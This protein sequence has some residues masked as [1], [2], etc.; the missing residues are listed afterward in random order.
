MPS[1]LKHHKL[2]LL[3]WLMSVPLKLFVAQNMPWDI[4]IVPV[5][6]R[7]AQYTLTPVGTLASVAAY[8]L[9]MLEWLHLPA[10]WLTGDVWWTIVLTLLT[11]N[12]LG[13]LAI[14]GL[15]RSMFSQRVGLVAGILFT[16]SEVGVSSSYTAWAQLLLPAFFA[17][18]LYTLWLWVK[19]EKGYWLALSGIIATVAFMTHFSAVLLYP[20]M[21][22]F[23]I[24][25][26]AKWQWNWLIIGAIII[27]LLFTPYILFQIE[28]DFIDARAF[29]TQEPLVSNATLA[30]YESYK[31]EYRSLETPTDTDNT[32]SV[33]PSL[34]VEPSPPIVRPRWQRAIDYALEAPIWYWRAMTTAFITQTRAIN[35]AI[36]QLAP[37]TRTFLTLQHVLLV[38][39]ISTALFHYLRNFK[40]QK[41]LTATPSGRLLLVTGFLTVYIAI[42]LL[43]RTID[44]SSYWMG[45]M[46][47]QYLILAYAISLVPEQNRIINA[48][49]VILLIAYV[50]LQT[51]ERSLRIIQHDDSQFSAFNVSIYR[52]VEAT[53][54]YIA[55]DWDSDAVTI[56]YDILPIMPNLWWVPAWHTIDPFYTMGMNFDFLLS[57]HH[58]IDNTNTDPVGTI[59]PEL[60]DYIVIY[61]P[62]QD[63]YD[64]TQYS[65]QQFG[66]ILVLKPLSP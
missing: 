3:I 15:G 36:P 46:S 23:A 62:R 48:I 55:E 7:N 12:L 57:Y 58:G 30:Q 45:F 27:G 37:I 49:A 39:S 59:Q 14:Y 10:Q 34:P 11:I 56:S 24:V 22:A 31:I 61:T 53:V 64:L 8:N 21:L 1:F 29:I 28:R 43:T 66:T 16:F 18:T 65:V 20:T 41:S 54:D 38:V 32:Q 19:H 5:V 17:M 2:I 9:P 6:A 13:T 60:A 63:Q 26:R 51:T 35:L 4:D 42:M 44:N 50:G 33:A 52:H 40:K 25:T 47:I